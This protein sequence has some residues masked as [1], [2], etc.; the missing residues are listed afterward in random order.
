MKP[1][2]YKPKKK[3]TTKRK[4]VLT[5]LCLLCY[6]ALSFI[7]LPFVDKTYIQSL[8]AANGSLN[9]LDILSGG[10]LGNMS[11]M[12]LGIAPWITAS[13]VLQLIGAAFPSFGNLNN[14]AVGKKTY[15]RITF[16]VSAAFAL[17][18]SIGLMMGHRHAGYLANNAW[19][20]VLVPALL[21]TA[22]TGI[23]SLMA[24]YMDERLL[25][26]GSSLILTAGILSSYIGDGAALITVLVTGKKTW[27]GVMSVTIALATVAVLFAYTVF[28]LSCEK[29]I[30][31]VYSKKLRQAGGGMVNVI[32]L[33]LLSGGVV[34]VIFASTIITAPAL[35]GSLS[36]L[37]TGWLKVF[38]T[39]F[40]LDINTPWASIGFALYIGLIIGFSYFCHLLYV[41]PM[42]LAGSLQ[43]GGGVI[44]G[45]RPGK[46]T[47]DYITNQAR[48]LTGLGGIFLCVIAAT[49]IVASGLF[50]IPDLSFLG[51]SI[52]I[53]AGTINDVWKAVRSSDLANTYASGRNKARKGIF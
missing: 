45:I 43:K 25:G 33:K 16:A 46:P 48:W 28:I 11:F 29:R 13:I 22:G 32:P 26:Y 40:W 24:W 49:P 30:K 14:D 41:N 50:K 8:A 42:E 38:N 17:A 6:R 20:A 53:T 7:P 44:P 27:M 23:L 12:A 36:G 34:P 37:D 52:L 15:K 35:I 18:E 47:A 3:F 1:K 19:Y 31:A 10:S 4:L 51:T 21:M 2:G 5:A 9:F 39:S